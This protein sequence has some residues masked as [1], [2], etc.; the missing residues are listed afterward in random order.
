LEYIKDKATRESISL[1]KGIQTKGAEDL[2]SEIALK[3]PMC[4]EKLELQKR[5]EVKPA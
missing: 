3:C 2:F 1:F 5:Q 4:G